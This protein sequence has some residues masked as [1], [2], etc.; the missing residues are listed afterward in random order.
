MQPVFFDTQI[1]LIKYKLGLL[2]NISFEPN[3]N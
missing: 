3:A 1:V 2:L